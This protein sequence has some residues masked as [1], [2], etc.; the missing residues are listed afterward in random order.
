MK[1][2]ERTRRFI[3]EFK[4]HICE[5]GYWNKFMFVRTENKHLVCRKIAG[6]TYNLMRRMILKAKDLLYVL[7]LLGQ[8]DNGI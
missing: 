8:T 6:L 3:V 4:V 7:S 2:S 5:V 1:I